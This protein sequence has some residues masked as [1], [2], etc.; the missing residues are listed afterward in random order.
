MSQ[1]PVSVGLERRPI[2]PAAGQLGP[3]LRPRHRPP[4]HWPHSVRK[5]PSP[6][7]STR[8]DPGALV[9]CGR[10]RGRKY[11]T[12]VTGDRHARDVRGIGVSRWA[13]ARRERVRASTSTNA[14]RSRARARGLDT[15]GPGWGEGERRTGETNGCGHVQNRCVHLHTGVSTSTRV[16]PL[17]KRVWPLRKGSRVIRLSKSRPASRSRRHDSWRTPSSGGRP[18]PLL[19]AGSARYY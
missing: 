2:T 4:R 7:R 18:T 6:F 16:W 13:P 10:S 15:P 12:T 19:A 5:C 17:P 1:R 11:A 9:R 3:A 8:S 14:T